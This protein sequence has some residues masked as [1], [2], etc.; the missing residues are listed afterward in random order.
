[1]NK[2]SEAPNGGE[3]E[4]TAGKKD[5]PSMTAPSENDTGARNSQDEPGV[6][7]GR[8]EELKQSYDLGMPMINKE[9][10]VLRKR[11][12]ELESA[13]KSNP[14]MAGENP[15]NVGTTPGA[16]GGATPGVNGGLRH[17]H[18]AA[19]LEKLVSPAHSSTPAASGAAD[20]E[21]FSEEQ[22]RT[23]YNSLARGRH[24]G[25]AREIGEIEKRITRAVKE[26]RV[27]GR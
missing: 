1:M 25:S 27:T 24:K 3:T 17:A 11:T 22:I 23:F 8:Y 26:G 20:T 2:T 10:D 15:A 9:L 19:A 7:K 13:L 6:W 18:T 4:K 5:N 16:N 12:A 21:V 14:D